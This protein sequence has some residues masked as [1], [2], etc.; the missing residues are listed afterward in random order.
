MSYIQ[1]AY[2]NALLADAAYIDLPIGT[3]VQDQLEDKEGTLSRRMTPQLAKFI[4]D[5]FEVA[6]LRAGSRRF[7]PM[8]CMRK[9]A[10]AKR[11]GG[12]GQQDGRKAECAAYFAPFLI[13]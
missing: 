8:A 7:R 4:A 9:A 5:N 1:S 6:R 12:H 13:A 3:I 11:A 10:R 2:I